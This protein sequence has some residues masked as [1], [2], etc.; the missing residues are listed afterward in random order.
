MV[1]G[2]IV[3]LAPGQ[4]STSLLISPEGWLVNLFEIEAAENGTL[5]EPPWCFVKT[6]FGPLQGHVALVE[7]L[8]AIKREFITNLEVND[9]GRYWENR[10]PAEL[11]VK[12]H[13]LSKAIDGV[14]DKIKQYGLSDEAAEQVA[15]IVRKCRQQR[16]ASTPS[17]ARQRG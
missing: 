10:D 2:L 12:I 8:E 9:E 5:L 16:F 11:S 4:D 7:L 13:S 15:R 14:A 1:R 6:Q 17:V 3:D